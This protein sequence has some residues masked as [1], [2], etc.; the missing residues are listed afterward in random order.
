MMTTP[1]KPTLL[2]DGEC[3]FC[4]RWVRRW[5]KATGD[6]VDYRPYQDA[7]AEFP[8]VRAADCVKA[9]QLVLPNGSI[10]Q[11]AHA[12]F[13]AL[14]FG[15]RARLALWLYRHS[16]VFRFCAEAAY[17]FVARNRSTF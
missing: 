10:L 12:V 9:V 15:E 8:Q 17:R 4:A 14:V 11:G 6:A 16:R 7:L 1:A 13:Q 5:Q 3:G 2:W